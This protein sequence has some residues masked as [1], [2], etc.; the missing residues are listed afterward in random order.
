M[1]SVLRPGI[2]LGCAVMV[3]GLFPAQA[4]IIVSTSCVRAGGSSACTTVRSRTI[5]LPAGVR[6][7]TARAEREDAEAAER[8][9]LWLARCRPT[10]EHDQ[11]GVR[12]Y[13][14]AA[15]GCEYGRYE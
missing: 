5:G 12:R 1:L 10:V 13:R 15:V 7:W 8:E 14:Y 3:M 4:D 11:Y 9:R 2:W 6:L